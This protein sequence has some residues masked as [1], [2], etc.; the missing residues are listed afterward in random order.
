MDSD[1]GAAPGGAD[2]PQR[3]KGLEP[4]G[5]PDLVSQHS[6]SLQTLFALVALK[7]APSSGR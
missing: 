4:P 7:T 5:D 6:L 2:A 3:Q 1:G